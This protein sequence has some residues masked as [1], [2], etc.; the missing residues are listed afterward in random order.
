MKDS[1]AALMVIVAIV[2]LAQKFVE[3]RTAVVKNRELDID[4]IRNPAEIRR[5]IISITRK[6]F[7]INLAF[8]VFF[9]GGIAYCFNHIVSFHS[10]SE[11]ASRDEIALLVFHVVFLVQLVMSSFKVMANIF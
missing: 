9:I 10:Y 1:T 8:L 11:A 6:D 3:L 7:F 2:V 5:G 4:T